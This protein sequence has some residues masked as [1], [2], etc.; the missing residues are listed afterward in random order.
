MLSARHF[1]FVFFL[2]VCA[3]GG[4]LVPGGRRSPPG[5]QQSDTRLN[6]VLEKEQYGI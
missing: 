6:E 3:Q 4:V 2:R 5:R 1:Q